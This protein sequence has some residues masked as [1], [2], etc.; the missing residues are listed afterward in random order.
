MVSVCV[1]VIF[2]HSEAVWR[3][4]ECKM[5]TIWSIRI[6]ANFS[7]NHWKTCPS[8]LWEIQVMG[9]VQSWFRFQFH[10]RLW[11]EHEVE[12]RK[13]K[14]TCHW[15]WRFSTRL[16][17]NNVQVKVSSRQKY[18]I[19]YQQTTINIRSMILCLKYSIF[20]LFNFEN[21][22]LRMFFFQ[23]KRHVSPKEIEN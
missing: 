8:N 15:S 10:R 17:K 7:E 4:L 19:K 1:E 5:K 14:R 20:Q 2:D 6:F 13:K 12:F 11:W 21:F 18:V 9:N 22:R 3:R 16:Q 23:K